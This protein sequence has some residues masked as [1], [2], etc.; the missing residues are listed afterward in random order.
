MNFPLST[1][2][3]TM[4]HKC[5]FVFTFIQMK[6]FS[7]FPSDVIFDL[8]NFQILG[9]LPLDFCYDFKL[10]PTAVTVTA[11]LSSSSKVW[12][13]PSLLPSVLYLLTMEHFLC[14]CVSRRFLWSARAATEARGNSTDTQEQHTLH[15]ATGAEG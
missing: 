14:I 1:A 7:N 8:F 13:S 10:K 6:I 3:S 2:F 4:S 15:K 5:C 12:P 11:R 9:D